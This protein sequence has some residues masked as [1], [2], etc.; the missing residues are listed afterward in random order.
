MKQR[1]ICKGL[2]VAVIIF[3]VSVGITSSIAIENL[4]NYY[5]QS[6]FSKILY[7]G[8]VGPDNYTT[9]QD[10]INNASDGFTI[11]VYSGTYDENIVI[12]RSI[13]L[14]G[15]NRD[16]TVINGD[17]NSE[18]V[19]IDVVIAVD[20][21]DSVII[22]GFTIKN[23]G[24]Q[25][26]I[27]TSTDGHTFMDNIITM[28]SQGIYLNDSDYNLVNNNLFYNN[29]M[30]GIF[31]DGKI[32]NI[33]N[34][35][36]YNSKKGIYNKGY[37]ENVIINNEIY[38]NSEQGI[39][40]TWSG[41]NYILNNYIHDNGE[42]IS[43]YPRN[44]GDIIKNNIIVFN[45]CGI[46]FHGNITRYSQYITISHNC[47]NDNIEFGIKFENS[48]Y[49]KIEN[50]E[51]KRNGI[52][53]YFAL[54]SSNTIK[55]NEISDSINSELVFL[56]SFFDI[57]TNNNIEKVQQSSHI[58]A[59]IH[60]GFVLAMSNWW[61]SPRYPLRFYVPDLGWLLV[62]PWETKPL[63]LEVGPEP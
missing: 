2:T 55:C 30:L 29:S 58:L 59:E 40:I 41:K 32:N 8:G 56:L 16:E 22:K 14:M 26:G 25:I 10:A 28:N 54:T 36:F 19:N 38:N 1:T 34:N 6:S 11:Y 20:D 48:Y 3:F 50:N 63:D 57:V 5:N 45:K 27:I 33:S 9:I 52:G 35:K 44:A 24:S 7:V 21:N 46:Y 13:I 12:D 18:T 60:F 17:G 61:G 62:T 42:G 53:I 31:I 51:I 4:G 49:N 23:D 43:F 15:E 47:I 37:R 39:Y